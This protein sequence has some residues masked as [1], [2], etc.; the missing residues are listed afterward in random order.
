[1]QV[2]DLYASLGLKLD[3]KQWAEGHSVISGIGK[4]LGLF[5]GYEAVKG[6]AGIVEG[7][8]GLGSKLN[9]LSQSTGQNVETLQELGYA[10]KLNGSDLDGMAMGLNKLSKNMYAAAN[11]SKEQAE[12]FAHLGVKVKDSTG[13]LRPSEDVLADLADHFSAMPDG[14]KKTAQAISVLGKS[15]ASLIPT[16]NGG[17]KELN[18]MRQEFKDL[19]GEIKK[20]DISN[21]DDLG[22]NVDRIKTAWQGIKNQAVIALVPVL[23]ELI[24]GFLEWIKANRQI[25]A[26]RI[27]DFIRALGS[28]LQFLGTALAFVVDHW[29]AFALLFASVKFSQAIL[30]IIKLFRILKTAATLAGAQT[31]LAWAAAALPF[32]LIAALIALVALAFTKYKE[33]TY[34]VLTAIQRWVHDKMESLKRG[35]LSFGNFLA[36][37]IPD[38]IVG[39][40]EAAGEAI[41]KALGGAFDWVMEKAKGVVSTIAG[42]PGIKQAIWVERKLAESVNGGGSKSV[43][44][45]IQNLQSFQQSI[46]G[47]SRNV[48]T[49]TAAAPVSV[50]TGDINIHTD[51][52]N[53]K[54]HGKLVFDEILRQAYAGTGA[55]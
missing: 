21:L 3:K 55:P 13:Q 44:D 7:V 39:A 1:M 25:L 42:L 6:L 27:D 32:V 4:A 15:G 40:F 48:A 18:K 24:T 31:L 45:Q 11:G 50:T 28:A 41:R 36:H 8:V 34:R 20:G 10:A 53:P 37:T 9:D 22:D 2:A 47:A 17:S 19:G 38:A 23:K 16:L 30:G 43:M 54:E 35:L 26:Q 14:T 33:Q 52:T 51:S 29:E 12:A 46:G 49:N 5:A